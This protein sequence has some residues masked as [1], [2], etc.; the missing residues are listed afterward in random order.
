MPNKLSDIDVQFISLVKK[1]ANGKTLIWKSDDADM[2][3]PEIRQFTIAKIDDEKRMVYGIVYSPGEVDS[4]DDMATADEIEKAAHSFMKN[5]RIDKVDS[6]H[7]YDPDEGYVA[8]SW[9]TKANDALFPDDPEGSWAVGIKIEDDE[10]WKLVKSG[11]YS[12]LSM[13][14][15]A[16]REPVEKSI[17]AKIKEFLPFQ[18]D[19]NSEYKWE[20]IWDIMD[21]LGRALWQTIDNTN[22]TGAERR[23]E[24]QTS[25]NQFLD[26]LDDK[27]MVL[28][29]DENEEDAMKKEEVQEVVDERLDEK[30]K[31]IQDSLEKLEK[32][33]SDD[34]A[35]G[36]GDSQTDGDQEFTKE[37]FESLQQRIESLEKGTKGSGQ[38]DGQ[39]D[40]DGED[41]EK[42]K[43]INFV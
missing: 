42:S 25:F 23:A 5:K 12:G 26:A 29:S 20:E 18:K 43:G 35:D 28:K 2:D 39:D 8:E 3:A 19:F 17:W 38:P 10:T 22:L 1:G 37:D 34:G 13:A 30:L 16:N 4:Q 15:T 11:D 24:M 33:Q 36:D 7:D 9:L 32:A 41:V 6:D 40:G 27:T 14:G 21:A 31:P